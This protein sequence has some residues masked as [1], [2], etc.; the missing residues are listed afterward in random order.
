MS[1]TVNKIG[2]DN[3][4]DTARKEINNIDAQ[5][6]ELFEARM[7]ASELVSRYKLENG[8]PV[9]DPAREEIVVS[10]N[11]S[12]IKNSEYKP[13]YEDFIKHTM[14]LSRRY[15]RK[16]ANQGAVGYQGVSG[17]YSYIALRRLFGDV[18]T[19]AYS[20][21]DG[22]IK[23]LL[24]DEIS[25]GV[26]PVCNSYAGEVTAV[27]ELLE[28][29][30]CYVNETYSLKIEHCILGAK[31]S[32]LNTIKTVT[33]HPQ[34]LAQCAQYISK[35]GFETVSAPNTAIAARQLSESGDIYT[36]AIASRETAALYGLVLLEDGISTDMDNTTKFAVVSKTGEKSGDG[37][38][39]RDFVRLLREALL[40]GKGGQDNV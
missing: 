25:F 13:Y 7:A 22:V 16:L 21:F 23:A 31:G 27:L 24:D 17:S 8:L 30:N 9:Y 26:L 11:T 36:A 32:S 29:S 37:K 12:L 39:G 3:L 15:Q 20:S 14:S 2:S 35:H 34:A 33:S 6:A 28:Q 1:E 38:R 5:M 40:S 18:S 10:R 19:H 4:L